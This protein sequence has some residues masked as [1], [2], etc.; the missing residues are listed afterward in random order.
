MLIKTF[1]IVS[2]VVKGTMGNHCSFFL[3]S[4]LESEYLKI[5]LTMEEVESVY[6]LDLE[7]GTSIWYTL[8]VWLKA[9]YFAGI[10]VSDI[11]LYKWT[12]FNDNR[13]FYIMNKNGKPPS[14]KIPDKA[15]TILDI[16]KK[17][18]RTNY[19]FV[20]FG[21]YCNTFTGSFFRS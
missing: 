14:L 13:L 20:Q 2:L 21:K 11:V 1:E 17:Q 7:K 6:N 15:K 18:K 4:K 5:G 19:G 16:Y 3:C 10:R 12:D 9:F 8:L